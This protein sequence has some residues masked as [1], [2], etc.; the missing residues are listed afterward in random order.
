MELTTS[1]LEAQA[2]DK[3]NKD[4]HA[5]ARSESTIPMFNWCPRQYSM[6]LEPLSYSKG[7]NGNRVITA[8]FFVFNSSSV[9][10]MDR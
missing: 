5:P 6:L 7:S 9:Q 2:L 10:L 4:T 8:K 1:I 3:H